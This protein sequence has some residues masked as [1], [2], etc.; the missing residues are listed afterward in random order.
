MHLWRPL[1]W[2]K[3]LQLNPWRLRKK[4]LRKLPKKKLDRNMRVLKGDTSDDNEDGECNAGGVTL[5][6]LFLGDRGLDD[7]QRGETAG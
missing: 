3:L 4:W 2:N 7:R 1:P 6:V 5:S